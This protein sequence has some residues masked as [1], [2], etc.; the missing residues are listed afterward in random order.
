M[1]AAVDIRAGEPVYIRSFSTRRAAVAQVIGLQTTEGQQWVRT[2]LVTDW[3]DWDQPQTAPR[4]MARS[5]DE[6]LV[7]PKHLEPIRR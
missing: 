6:L 4:T 7:D 3:Y 1:V 2:R 5:G